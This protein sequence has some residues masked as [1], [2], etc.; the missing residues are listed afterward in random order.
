MTA[1]KT[2]T[3]VIGSGISGLT[4][5]ALLAR[6]GR[7]VTIV[8]A[9]RKP[10][11]ALRRFTREGIP[12]DVGFH[13]SSGLGKGQFLR[14]LWDC[15]G[16]GGTISTTSLNPDGHDLLRLPTDDRQV[17]AY[18]SYDRLGEEL[19]AVFPRESSGIRHYLATLRELSRAMPFYNPTL[20]LT[21]YLRGGATANDRPLTE[22]IGACTGNPDLQA[23]LSAP[24]FLYGVPPKQAGLAMHAVV[25]HGYYSG[26]WGIVGGGQAIVEALVAELTRLGVKIMTAS[27]VTALKV[28]GDRVVGVSGDDWQLTATNVVYSGH[29]RH[30]P[31]LLPAEALRPAYRNRLRELEDTISMHIVFA[32]VAATTPLPLLDRANLYRLRPGFA[33]LEPPAGNG[34]DTLMITA[35]GRHDGPTA[36][37]SRGVIMMRPAR[38]AEVS[39]FDR[40]PKARGPGYAEFKEQLTAEMLADAAD[41][42]GDEFRTI[43]PLATGTPLTFRD[44]LGSP[45]GGVY[46]V[47][48]SRDQRPA[49]ARTKLPGLYL[50][51]QS[52]LM[53]G[54]MGASL[55]G[56]V[57]AGEIVGLEKVWDMVRECC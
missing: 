40:G 35:P 11:G 38:L 1:T 15:L 21:P 52:S 5:A 3:V 19:C 20:P 51:G 29:P 24:T 17:R 41:A 30:L 18:Y 42:F 57:S 44:R 37:A 33:L 54:L 6:C 25:A 56:L 23:V 12:F 53:P 22:V 48:N 28:E 16:V 4:T 26:A 43:R 32:E 46:G 49:E 10:G 9:K 7:E 55:A 36:P 13:Y 50:S 47:R 31:G 2:N 34:P 27:P 39:G 14:A 8:E 45:A